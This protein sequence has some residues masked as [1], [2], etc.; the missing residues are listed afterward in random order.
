MSEDSSSVHLLLS[1][2]QIT[3]DIRL[4]DPSDLLGCEWEWRYTEEGEMVRVS[5]RTGRL[6]PIPEANNHTHDYRAASA[7]VER[8]KDTP[9]NEYLLMSV[10][11]R[12]LVCS[13]LLLLV[14]IGTEI[15]KVTFK[16][17]L[18]TFEMDIMDEMGIKEDRIAKPTYWY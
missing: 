10:F 2:Q 13:N 8:P 15:G 18:C 3:K 5:T 16:P 6:I 12:T 9:G 11:L 1:V 14:S 17:K 7:Y 4:V